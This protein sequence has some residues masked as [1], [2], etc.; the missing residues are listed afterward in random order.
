MET[1]SFL[2]P[3]EWARQQ[4]VWVGWPRLAGEWGDAF[5]VARTEIAGF[6]R[7]LTQTVPVQIAIGDDAADASARAHGLA[8][9]ILRRI[10]S[11]DIWLRDTGPIVSTDGTTA[12]ADIFAFNGWGG[13]FIMP[14]DRET[15]PAL[16]RQAGLEI[17]RHDSVLEGGALD[18]DGQGTILTTRACLLNTNRNSWSQAEAESVLARTLGARR[19]IWLERGLRHDHTD[20]H[21]DNIARFIAPGRVACHRSVSRDDPQADR[22]AAAEDTLRAAGLEVVTIPSPG[23]VMNGDDI[24][25]ASHLNFVFANGAI[26]L[27]TYDRRAGEAAAAALSDALPNWAVKPLPSRAIVSGGGSFHC[28]TCNIPATSEAAQ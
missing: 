19:I 5:D 28:M 16:A 18:H 14:G 25:P 21:I 26:L 13:K 12:C 10:P 11:G 6:I 24:A 9:S 2:V 8:P 7:Q 27:P 20:G 15:A 1:A 17:R 23:A 4:A 3:P 22:F